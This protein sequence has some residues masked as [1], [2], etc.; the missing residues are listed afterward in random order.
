MHTHTHTNRTF[1]QQ[2]LFYVTTTHISTDFICFFLIQNN[3]HNQ[4]EDTIKH[5]LGLT[6]LM[7][8][9]GSSFTQLRENWTCRTIFVNTQSKD[10]DQS[11]AWSFTNCKCIVAIIIDLFRSSTCAHCSINNLIKKTQKNVSQH[12]QIF[13]NQFATKQFQNSTEILELLT[14]PIKYRRDWRPPPG[15]AQNQIR[16]EQL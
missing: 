7:E 8:N 2:L 13:L 10:R 16:E 6:N 15:F 1:L 12:Y 4:R 3:L 5:H 9:L 11:L 14:T